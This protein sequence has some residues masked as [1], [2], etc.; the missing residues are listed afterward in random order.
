MLLSPVPGSIRIRY[1]MSSQVGNP[2]TGDAVLPTDPDPMYSTCDKMF[3]PESDYDDL[4]MVAILGG[5]DSNA[6]IPG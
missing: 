6:S 5:R 1:E 3:T 2:T 4:S